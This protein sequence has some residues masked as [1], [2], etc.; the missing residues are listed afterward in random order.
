MQREYGNAF[1]FRYVMQAIAIRR[2]NKLELAA[3]R[4]VI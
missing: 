3:R 4:R 2:R 1:D